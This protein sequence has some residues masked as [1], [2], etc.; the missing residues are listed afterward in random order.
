MIERRVRDFRL[1]SR[2]RSVCEDDI[3]TMCAFLGDSESPER[4]QTVINCLQVGGGVGRE[5]EQG[6]VTGDGR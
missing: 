4:D 6:R 5:G 1:D 2:L 3:F